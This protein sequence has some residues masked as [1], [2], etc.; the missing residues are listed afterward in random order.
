MSATKDSA[1]CA[2]LPEAFL[3]ETVGNFK[4]PAGRCAEIYDECCRDETRMKKY[5]RRSDEARDD[6]E[7]FLG[8]LRR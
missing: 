7:R 2:D 6:L 4:V 5:K 8:E 1:V 3:A